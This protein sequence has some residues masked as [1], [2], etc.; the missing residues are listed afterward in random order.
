MNKNITADE[1]LNLSYTDFISLIKETNR[2]PGGK[3]TIRKIVQNS[4]I[5][6]SSRVLD[7]GSNTGFTSLEI[8]HISKCRISGIDVSS[9]CVTTA[10]QLLDKD[11]E[12]VKNRVSFQIGSAYDIP[13]DDCTFDLVVT[14]GATSFMDK[15]QK[16]ISE[17]SRVLKPWGLLSATQLFYTKE[18][19]KHVTDA[20]SNAIGVQINPWSEADWKNV[21]LESQENSK[22]ELYY[23]ERNELQSRSTKIIDEYINYFLNKPHLQEYNNEIKDVIRK[24]WRNYIEV[25]NENHKYLGYFISLFRKTFYPEE[26]ELFIKKN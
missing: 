20:V 5:D 3:D 6:S 16:A 24:K 2:C 26:T 1:V 25:F 8:A 19:P 23:Y 21:F 11:I 15:K 4:F 22:L 14:G 18:P 9:E 7:V 12:E 10:N 13:F 17:Y